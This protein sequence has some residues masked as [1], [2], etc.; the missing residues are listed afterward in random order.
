MAVG[1]PDVQVRPPV[2]IT[3]KADKA[4]CGALLRLGLRSALALPESS[5]WLAQTKKSAEFPWPWLIPPTYVLFG[6]VLCAMGSSSKL[7]W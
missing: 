2:E 5:G 3:E 1:L 6:A 4:G 7:I